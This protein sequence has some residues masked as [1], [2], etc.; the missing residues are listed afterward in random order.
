M[1]NETT[2]VFAYTVGIWAAEANAYGEHEPVRI[3]G[4]VEASD[5][6]SAIAAFPEAAGLDRVS[7]MPTHFIGEDGLEYDFR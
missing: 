3:F 5:A 2:K 6:E 7:A 4:D 1:N